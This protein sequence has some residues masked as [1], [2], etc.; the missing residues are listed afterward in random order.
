M[1]VRELAGARSRRRVIVG[2]ACGVLAAVCMFVYLADVRAQAVNVRRDAVERY[3]GDVVEVCVASRDVASGEVLGAGDVTLQP[4][5]VDLLPAGAVTDAGDVAGATARVPLLANEVIAESKVGDPLS[6]VTVP[7][8]LCAVSVASQDVLAVGGAIRSGSLVNVYSSGSGVSLIGENIL[9][10]ETSNSGAGD[11]GAGSV[12]G[13]A[14]GRSSISWVTLAVAPESVEEL[15]AA[16]K[17]GNLYFALPGARGGSEAPGA[18]GG[19]ES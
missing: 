10:L 8:G 5:P 12:F 2:V 14:S 11:A 18:E 6:S 16:S 9:V 19:G 15:I 13:N 3:G 17:A 4:W 1:K 7:D